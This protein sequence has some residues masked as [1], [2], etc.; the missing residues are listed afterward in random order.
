MESENLSGTDS[1]ESGSIDA[2]AER[3]VAAQQESE[4]AQEATE[5]Q[6]DDQEIDIKAEE[7]LSEEDVE[8]GSQDGPEEE[9]NEPEVYTL[10]ELA[11]AMEWSTDDLS[12]NLQ[13][14]V[15][16]NGKQT[17]VT[18][19]DLR[20]GYQKGE[21]FTEKTQELANERKAF[22]AQAHQAREEMTQ[23]V[24][25]ASAMADTLRN[26][27]MGEY[28]NVDWQTLRQTD[29]AE[30]A[31]LL[32][33]FQGRQQQINKIGADVQRSQEMQRVEEQQRSIQQQQKFLDV[34][35]KALFDAIPEWQD[36]ATAKAGQTQMRNFLM[37]SYGFNENDV[38][39][40]SDHRFVMLAR[41][42]MKGKK[43][44]TQADI[45]K[46][47][48]KSAPKLIKPGVKRGKAQQQATRTKDLRSKLRRSGHVDDVAALLIDRM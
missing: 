18:L 21:R 7:Q 14:K 15:K 27:L 40:V 25:H 26:N 35:R 13:V 32:S 17:D 12:S 42:A 46:K 34:E 1:P 48:V 45:G 22:E 3:I 38:N 39:A 23:R 28:Q 2:I 9:S 47:K 24:N 5:Q 31:A 44:A 19:G 6:P 30:Y 41:D 16:V 11:D 37:E 43:T 29:P 4:P 33:D 36:E 10:D 8:D 20:D